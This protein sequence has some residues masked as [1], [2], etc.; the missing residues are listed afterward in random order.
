MGQGRS[1]QGPG[2][3]GGDSLVLDANYHPQLTVGRRPL[4]GT[5]EGGGGGVLGG[6]MGEI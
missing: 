6:A 2:R 5:W 4:G 1:V 3:G